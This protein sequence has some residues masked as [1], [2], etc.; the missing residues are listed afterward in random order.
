[1]AG[2]Q[3]LIFP[4]GRLGPEIDSM[5]EHHVHH[6]S[7]ARDSG[8]VLKVTRPNYSGVTCRGFL[9]R[10]GGVRLMEDNATPAEY[11]D[12]WE[13][14]NELFGGGARFE[15]VIQ[16]ANGP[17]IVISQ[18]HVEGRLPDDTEMP[19]ILKDL[20]GHPTGDDHWRRMH[21][22]QLIGL[23]DTKPSNWIKTGD[24]ASCGS[25]TE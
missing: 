16:T 9:L 23:S 7:E 21:R 19:S 12:R 10:D 25:R 20:G 17:A 8:R 4:P 5:G 2:E 24:P 1:M 6:P 15:G 13:L 11:F 3:G 22:G 14:H 18:P